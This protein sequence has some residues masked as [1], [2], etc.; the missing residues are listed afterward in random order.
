MMSQLEDGKHYRGEGSIGGLTSGSKAE[1]L[2][3]E[4][5]WGHPDADLDVMMLNGGRVG[6]YVAGGQQQRGQSCMEFRHEGCPPAYCKLEVTNLSGLR[7]SILEYCEREWCDDNCVDES[8]GRLWL[9]TFNAV[10]RMKDA[11]EHTREN[12]TVAGP[13]AQSVKHNMDTVQTFVCSGTTPDQHNEFQSRSRGP[14]PPVSLIKYIL[15]MPM[16]LV[17]VGHKGSPEPE[18]KQQARMSWSHLELKLIRRLPER[19]RQGYIA[20]KYVMKRFLKAHRSLNPAVDGRSSVC[21]Y[22]IKVT[23]LRFL[24]K[25]TPSEITSP[26]RLFLDLLYELKEYLKVGK[27]SHY[28]LADCNL[29]ELVADDERDIACQVIIKILS[30]PINALLTSPTDPQEIYGEVRPDD[31]VTAF[32]A[33]SSH[34][35]REQYWKLHHLL[36]RVDE[37]RRQRFKEQ[38]EEQEKSLWRVSGRTEI[39]SLTAKLN[40]IKL[41]VIFSH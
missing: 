41:G 7:R 38:Q 18:F 24:E 16:L 17:L 30:D 23:F 40:D 22:H 29:L 27:L 26:F 34:P 5:H 28:F 10:W 21:S 1:G 33:F 12:P 35:T 20:C 25:I 6:V 19:V 13:A 8:D 31:L 11:D 39:T 36:A 2:A 37:R 32:H 14:W 4:K 3:L 15:Q 9:N